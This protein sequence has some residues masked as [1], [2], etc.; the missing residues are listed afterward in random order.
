MRKVSENKVVSFET[1]SGKP[2]KRI[3]K[4]RYFVSM[5]LL[6]VLLVSITLC[7]L[8]FLTSMSQLDMIYFEGLTYVSRAEVITLADLREQPLMMSLN[9][10]EIANKMMEHPLVETVSVK[11]Q[12]G[13][14]LLITVK[15]KDIL[16]CVVTKSNYEY[17]L[18]D[19]TMINVDQF[20]NKVC[21][22]IIIDGM[23]QE[24]D[25][26]ALQLFVKEL[27]NVDR[28]FV[29]L[30]QEINYVP[31]YGDYNRFSIYLTDGNTV[32]VNSYT[33]AQKLTYYETM[34]LKVAELEGEVLG[35]YHLD[36]GDYFSPYAKD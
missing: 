1:K 21:E 34:V 7:I 33:M 28:A 9:E 18:N 16:G 11:K 12:N 35:T 13:N 26:A 19:G 6:A 20:P 29:H 30:I 24:T 15:E 4:R 10:K 3:K 23:N 32:T 22:G 5:G 14:D 2:F 25:A 31:E 27:A 36:V 17:V 8:Y